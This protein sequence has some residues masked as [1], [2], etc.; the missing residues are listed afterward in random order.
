MGFSV[1]SLAFGGHNALFPGRNLNFENDICRS[2]TAIW[3]WLLPVCHS[4]ALAIAYSKLYKHKLDQLL[5]LPELEICAL[6]SNLIKICVIFLAVQVAMRSF[7][8]YYTILPDI[9]SGFLP[10]FGVFRT[11]HELNADQTIGNQ[12]SKERRR[13]RCRRLRGLFRG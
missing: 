12:P 10:S 13:G 4:K 3:S 11:P 7:A 5:R 9:E 8:S 1:I 2:F 6:L